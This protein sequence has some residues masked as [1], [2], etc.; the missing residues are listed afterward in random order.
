M[1]EVKATPAMATAMRLVKVGTVYC[2][3][4]FLYPYLRDYIYIYAWF[5]HVVIVVRFDKNRIFL[6]VPF[7]IIPYS[8]RLSII[9]F[10]GT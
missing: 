7:F 2:V 1:T 9:L 8:V 10:Y 4:S 5:V 6:T 3:L